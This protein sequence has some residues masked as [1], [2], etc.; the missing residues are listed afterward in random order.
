MLK[1]LVIGNSN[2]GKTQLIN[3]FVS[4]KFDE[5]YRATIACDFAIKILE[6]ENTEIRLQM[7]DLQGQDR[8]IGGINKL[9]CKGATG[10]IVVADI[11]D[12]ES[13]ENAANWKT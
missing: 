12:I 5:E 13:I 8:A 3:R 6:L 4:N 9:F 1:I 11:T 10:A 2:A 7:W